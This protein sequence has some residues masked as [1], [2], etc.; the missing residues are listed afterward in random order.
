VALRLAHGWSQR[1]AADRWNERW[2]A[3][4]KTFKN[5]SYW[6]NWP[7]KTGYA[8][9]LDVLA[10]L[11]ELYECSVADLLVDYA[12]FRHCDPTHSTR[13]QLDQVP[14]AL[15]GA[16]G[17][18]AAPWT[19]LDPV[20]TADRLD[21]L[22]VAELA[23]LGMA[24]GQQLAGHTDVR[25]MLLKLSAGLTL[26]AAAPAGTG[27]AAEEVPAAPPSSDS[28]SLAGIWH[29]RYV[30]YSPG[31]TAEFEGEHY[32]VLRDQS[33]R[34]RLVGQSLPHSLDSRLRLDLT[35]NGL[36][37]TGTWSESTSPAGYYKGAV[38]HGTVQLLLDPIGRSIT[39]K[40]LGFGKTSR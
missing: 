13:Q 11:A 21:E 15:N 23:R 32:V 9:S 7:S 31:R 36:I 10:R 22:D 26:A 40:W 38:Y 33:G 39:G 8:P 20:A 3:D 6:E 29:S 27:V 1:Q 19:T 34:D 28:K 25:A 37:A 4:P 2:P 5:F 30:Y 24:W 14:T 35:I 12:D 17:D 18:G 16:T